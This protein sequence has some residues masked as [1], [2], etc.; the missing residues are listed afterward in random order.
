M[1]NA[2]DV[3][4]NGPLADCDGNHSL[5]ICVFMG[6]DNR[7]SGLQALHG[8]DVDG[9]VVF[10]CCPLE[11]SW[12]KNEDH[13]SIK[14]AAMQCLQATESFV[15]IHENANRPVAVHIATC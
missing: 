6:F 8:D 15:K 12:T 7:L 13:R 1:F 14:I 9:K 3:G 5:K 10:G 4:S 11:F 2:A